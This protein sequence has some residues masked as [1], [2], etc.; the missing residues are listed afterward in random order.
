MIDFYSF[1]TSNGLRACIVLAECELE[2]KAICQISN[3][4]RMQWRCGRG[5]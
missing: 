4:G 2:H 3:V 5:W 1:E